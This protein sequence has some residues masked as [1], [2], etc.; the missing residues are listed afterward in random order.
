MCSINTDCVCSP[1]LAI[2]VILT[3]EDDEN[4]VWL[5]KRKD[6]GQYAVMGGFLEVDESPEE[7]VLRELKEETNVEVPISTL[8]LF[9]ING[10][11]A[12]DARRHSMS[13]VYQLNMPKVK[14]IAGDDVSDV[15]RV[16]LMDEN[17]M[18]PENF[19]ADH[20][21]ILQDYKNKRAFKEDKT[22]VLGAVETNDLRSNCCLSF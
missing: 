5:V 21:N 9:G 2:D 13:V 7:A 4:F 16:N 11:P 20:F 15:V 3:D 22:C 19:F 12:R 10:D 14:P 1:S 17:M 6:T 8:S 18:R